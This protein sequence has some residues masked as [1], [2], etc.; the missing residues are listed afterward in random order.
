MQL[1]SELMKLIKHSTELIDMEMIGLKSFQYCYNSS[2]ST[3][4]QKTIQLNT[5]GAMAAVSSSSI[6]SN[7]INSETLS[8]DLDMI[9]SQN[10][11]TYEQLQNIIEELLVQ[12]NYHAENLKF[13]R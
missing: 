8:S 2:D 13:L 1:K 5:S 4:N 6:S 11:I 7:E 3:S 10:G 9:I 12:N